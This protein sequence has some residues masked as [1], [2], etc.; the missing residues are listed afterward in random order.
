MN[1][2]GE[3]QNSL[4]FCSLSFFII[5]VHKRDGLLIAIRIAIDIYVEI[6]FLFFKEVSKQQRRRGDSFA[7]GLLKQRGNNSVFS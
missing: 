5:L 4:L 6:V 7:C 1:G 3:W 2:V